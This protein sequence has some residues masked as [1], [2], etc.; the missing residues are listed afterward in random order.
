MTSE[1]R[2]RLMEFILQSQADSEVRLQRIEESHERIDSAHEKALK[3]IDRLER[4]AK[5]FVNA[6]RRERREQ[7]AVDEKVGI[8]ITSHI[9]VEAQMKEQREQ[10][11]QL[12]AAQAHNEAFT[13]KNSESIAELKEHI[14]RVTNNVDRLAETVERFIANKNGG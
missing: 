5:L 13:Q 7:R 2:K 12:I 8:L 3:R 11:A 6:G 9:E 4:L 1:E 10:L 14:D